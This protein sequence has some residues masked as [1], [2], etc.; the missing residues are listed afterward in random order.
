MATIDIC[1]ETATQAVITTEILILDQNDQNDQIP[2]EQNGQPRDMVCESQDQ[3]RTTAKNVRFVDIDDNCGGE[4]YSSNPPPPPNTDQLFQKQQQEEEEEG[5]KTTTM[6]TTT[7]TAAATSSFNEE[8]WGATRYAAG[9]EKLKRGC[10]K[11]VTDFSFFED[12]L[13]GMKQLSFCLEARLA[14]YC[15]QIENKD[16][17]VK[18]EALKHN[19][20]VSLA[21]YRYYIPRRERLNQLNS[22]KQ[23][24][25]EIQKRLSFLTSRKTPTAKQEEEKQRCELT[26]NK[27]IL[28]SEEEKER[29]RLYVEI[30]SPPSSDELYEMYIR[31]TLVQT[32]KRQLANKLETKLVKFLKQQQPQQQQTSSRSSSSTKKE[33]LVFSFDDYVSLAQYRFYLPRQDRINQYNIKLPLLTAEE[34]QER[35]RLYREIQNPP[36]TDELVNTYIRPTLEKAREKFNIDIQLP[37]TTTVTMAE[38]V[39]V[40]VDADV[41]DVNIVDAIA[42]SILPPVSGASTGT[43]DDN[44]EDCLDEIS[45]TT[46]DSMTEEDDED[47]DEDGQEE[48]PTC[49]SSAATTTSAEILDDGVKILTV[50]KSRNSKSKGKDDGSFQMGDDD[51]ESECSDDDDIDDVEEEEEE[52]VEANMVPKSLSDDEDESKLAALWRK[53]APLSDVECEEKGE[54]LTKK[55]KKNKID[56][57]DG[58][59]DGD[60]EWDEGDDDDDDD[61][62]DEDDDDDDDDDDDIDLDDDLDMEEIDEDVVISK[63]TPKRPPPQNNKKRPRSAMDNNNCV[64]QLTTSGLTTIRPPSPPSSSPSSPTAKKQKLV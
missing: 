24:A 49:S 20:Y 41:N 30:K 40:L 29:K 53:D 47:E 27:E 5:E 44:E 36:N 12:G 42:A 46:V 17:P 9:R 15:K 18:E 52:Y 35:K 26:L 34:K 50:R 16:E 13:C 1:S 63:K 3:N 7:P 19:E 64:L 11:A 6:T 60:D 14:Q 48:D 25:E 45:T 39:A 38:N 37:K 31:P 33:P 61:D 32:S 51:D 8:K 56:E 23:A 28:T 2:Q 62:E 22:R 21:E 59:I 55:K 43:E 54:N 57:K 10:R 58:D 4:I